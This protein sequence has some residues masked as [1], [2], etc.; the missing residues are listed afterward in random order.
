MDAVG[1]DKEAEE[2]ELKGSERHVCRDQEGGRCTRRKHAFPQVREEVG[3]VSGLVGG[4]AG[5]TFR[6]PSTARIVYC[7]RALSA[8][9]YA[10]ALFYGTLRVCCEAAVT[11]CNRR[12]VL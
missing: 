9:I 12:V 6:C 5:S 1:G 3:H 2:E 11:A 7:I 8:W 10:S 4:L